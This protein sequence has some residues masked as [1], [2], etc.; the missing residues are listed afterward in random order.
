MLVHPETDIVN[1]HLNR[2]ERWSDNQKG[3]QIKS[4]DLSQSADISKDDTLAATSKSGQMDESKSGQITDLPKGYKSGDE[5]R[6]KI[7]E[8]DTIIR[9]AGLYVMINVR[10]R[11]QTLSSIQ[12]TIKSL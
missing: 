4:V 2:S 6:S 1:S 8:T 3:G 12:M 5:S 11:N 9:F 7:V 10:E